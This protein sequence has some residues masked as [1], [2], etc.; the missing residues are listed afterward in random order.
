M[1]T[2]GYRIALVRK[3]Q[4]IE[5]TTCTD[6]TELRDAVY[7]MVRTEGSKISNSDHTHLTALIGQARQAADA[8]GFAAL[9]FGTAALTIRPGKE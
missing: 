5:R 2:A 1:T 8:D 6:E 7:D 9:E 4:P 3:G